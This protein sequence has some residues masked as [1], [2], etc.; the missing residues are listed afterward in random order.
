MHDDSRFPAP[1]YRDA[2]LAPL[3]DETRRHFGGYLDRVNRAH[4]V[5]LAEQGILSDED[6]A[7]I[8][9]ALAAIRRDTDFAAMTYTG[10]FEDLFFV[11][12]H[13]LGQQVGR[14]LAGRLHTGRSRNDMDVSIFKMA[15]KQRLRGMLRQVAA[16]A[17]RLLDVAARER[18]TLIVA[19]THGQPAQP[20]SFGHYLCAFAEVL[21]RDIDRLLHAH[22]DADLCSMGAAAITT[23]GFPLSRPRMAA[24]LG[25]SA[26]QENS[27]GCI[28]AADYLAS[29]Y[30]Q[31]KI[32]FINLGRVIQDLNSWS[33]FEM[34]QL[35]V[36]NSF[37][38]VSSIMPQKRNPVPIE[39]M[40]LLASHG[41]GQCDV[42][43]GTLHNTPFTDMNDAEG[44]TQAAG[45][46]AFDT[47]SRLLPLLSDFIGAVRIREDRVRATIDT[48][49]LGMTE[50]ADSL[51]REE[52]LSFR[53]AHEV[54]AVLSRRLIEAGQGISALTDAQFADAFAQVAGRAPALSP[55][56]L[57]RLTSP[58]HFLAV[59]TLPGGPGAL[60]ASLQGYRATLADRT[61][62]L[63]ALDAAEAAA[64]A[65]LDRATARLT[66]RS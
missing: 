34:A 10:E 18:A 16:L 24:L 59:R 8:L 46:A 60:E 30:G 64:A 35:Y 44:P 55:A 39:H 58:E 21:L 42:V 40:R 33:S 26:Y 49:C 23:T 13:L 4:A 15:L 66:D 5:M 48:A 17:E 51:V 65:E 7:R 47:A 41:M 29:A 12:E 37:V 36:P 11:T 53:Q 3:F 20:T 25:F 63:D 43:M 6:A 14:D 56:E 32:L 38:Q 28:A 1:A 62:R 2:V 27:Y 31:A 57:R 52:G 19:Y 61:A 45:Y 9:S 54:A 50:L 22:A